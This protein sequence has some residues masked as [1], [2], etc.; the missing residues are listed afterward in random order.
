MT[1]L[2]L[3]SPNGTVR[4]IRDEFVNVDRPPASTLV[5]VAGL[6]N[7]DYLIEIEAVAAVDAQ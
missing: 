5:R 4:N 1:E 3:P 6:V 2:F 7:P